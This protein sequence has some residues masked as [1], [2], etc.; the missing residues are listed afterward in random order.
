MPKLNKLTPQSKSERFAE[1]NLCE[2]LPLFQMGDD[3]TTDVNHAD[4]TLSGIPIKVGY[5]KKEFRPIQRTEH[6]ITFNPSNPDA[7][8]RALQARASLNDCMSNGNIYLDKFEAHKFA[9]DSISALEKSIKSVK[10]N[11]K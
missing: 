7:R 1:M 11:N 8:F 2:P 4:K 3:T 6:R 10:N 5:S 9:N